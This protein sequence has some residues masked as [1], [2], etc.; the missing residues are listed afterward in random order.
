MGKI[1]INKD[2]Y[3]IGCSRKEVLFE[4]MYDLDDG[5]M[6]NSYAIIDEKTAV[7]D[8]V[9]AEIIDEYIANV[10]SVLGKKTLDYLIIQHMEPDH[11]ASLTKLL[12]IY[13]NATIVMN[14]K[15]QKFFN[16]FKQSRDFK[17]S[18]KIVEDGETLD[19]G[20]HKLKFIFAPMVHW[21]EVMMTYDETT[22]TIYT[23]DAFGAFGSQKEHTGSTKICDDS[24]LKIEHYIFEM[25]EY[26]SNI[27]GKYG[28]QVLN[29]LNKLSQLD[30]KCICPL[31]GVVVKN[32]I[33]KVLDQYKLWASYTPECDGVLIV[34][35]TMYGNTKEV[36]EKI[37]SI[38]PKEIERKIYNLSEE[39]IYTIISEVYRFKKI[40]IAAP[41]YNGTVFPHMNEFLTRLSEFNMQNRKFAIV[42]NGTWGPIAGKVMKEK[43]SAL[44]NC[45]IC[46]KIVTITSSMTSKN[47]EELEELVEELCQ[48]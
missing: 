33:K 43:V 11:T 38:I 42:E 32:N 29:V 48:N 2:T 12:E 17:G 6:F 20:L 8:G 40:V 7:F 14:V 4:N 26:Y 9:E 13:P 46:E 22:Q 10:K 47:E 39:F 34:Y 1:E 25:R 36:A 21:P 3:Y 31:H 37:E 16:N 27:V 44:K 24:T 30:I 28:I 19:L 5:M 41:T 45:E 15:T 23:A 35:G 18:V